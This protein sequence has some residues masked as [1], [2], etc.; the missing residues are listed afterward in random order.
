MKEIA[1]FFVD[2]FIFEVVLVDFF[3]VKLSSCK[4]V[5]LDETL[6][7]E[8]AS[9]AWILTYRRKYHNVHNL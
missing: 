6:I 7:R 8:V 1:L 9:V 2:F 4:L 5:H 3:P